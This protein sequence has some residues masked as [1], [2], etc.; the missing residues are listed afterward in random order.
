MCNRT[1]ERGFIFLELAIGLPLIIMMLWA[2]SNLFAGT[3]KECRDL[4]ADFTMQI[5]VNNAMQRI[6]SDM[7]NAYRVERKG[8]HKIIVHN[9]VAQISSKVHGSNALGV[10]SD[11]DE[12]EDQ[13]AEDNQSI[14]EL[15]RPVVYFSDT[16]KGS[17]LHYIYRQRKDGAKSHP[18][19]G[20]DILSDVDAQV[21]FDVPE[22]NLYPVTIRAVSTISG[23]G[24][25]IRTKVFLGGAE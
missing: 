4:I 6:V 24:Y 25:E 21:Y 11:E 15:R 10:A 22:D 5:E 7:R 3:W 8:V 23:H 14:A 2:M 12:D 9:Y 16:K 18:I 19:T 20:M 13:K 17:D 1:I